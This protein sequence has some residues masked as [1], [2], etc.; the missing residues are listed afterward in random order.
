MIEVLASNCV[1][2]KNY[3]TKS[4]VY[5]QT[6]ATPRPVH[7]IASSSQQWSSSLHTPSSPLRFIPKHGDGLV[8]HLKGSLG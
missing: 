4:R 3:T 5:G 1:R 2:R 8:Q 6:S 7:G